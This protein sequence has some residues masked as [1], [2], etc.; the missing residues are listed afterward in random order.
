MSPLPGTESTNGRPRLYQEDPADG[1]AYTAVNDRSYSRTARIY[2]LAIKAVPIW[3][4]WIGRVL[5][6]IQGP[7]VLEVSCGTG[8]LLAQY[9]GE[10]NSY[11]VDLNEPMTRVTAKNLSRAGLRAGIQLANVEVLPYASASF[12]S[13]VNTMAFTGYP[14]GRQALAEITRVLKPGGRLLLV[15]INYP[16]DGNWLGW[17][18]VRMWVSFGDIIRDMESLLA[19]YGYRFE[20]EEVGGF[21]SVH[22][23]V[24]ISCSA[25][26]RMSSPTTLSDKPAC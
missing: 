25:P 10:Y 3:R 5:P 15:D 12:D 9:A 4:R 26:S 18:L 16:K 21:G 2:D 8:W 20:K 1:L 11:A 14:H 19:E 6:H 13:V 24:A 23:Y 22:L 7:R 17:R